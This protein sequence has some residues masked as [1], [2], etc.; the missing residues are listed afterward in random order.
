MGLSEILFSHK[1]VASMGPR[2]LGRGNFSEAAAVPEIASAS[3]GPRFL[4]RGNGGAAP[5]L[6]AETHAS[7]GPRFLG[8]GNRVF[9]ALPV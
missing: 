8:R 9:Y 4:G 1:R 6:A 7:M 3:M 5:K 2:F